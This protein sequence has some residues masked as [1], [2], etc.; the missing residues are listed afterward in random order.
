MLCIRFNVRWKALT[1]KNIFNT[2]YNAKKSKKVF[3]D[4][5]SKKIFE[6]K[7]FS[8]KKN[9]R[10]FL[11][12]QKFPNFFSK[13]SKKFSKSPMTL[14]FLSRHPL[15][16]IVWLRKKIRTIGIFKKFIFKKVDPSPP[17]GGG[18]HLQCNFGRV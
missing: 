8:K 3:R 2:K 16:L 11:K 14:I 9:F 6:K 5:L 18:Q 17:L 12:I 15:N 10:F 13:S 1:L 4:F 7:F